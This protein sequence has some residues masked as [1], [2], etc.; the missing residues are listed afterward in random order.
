MASAAFSNS[1]IAII[2]DDPG[3]HGQQLTQSLHMRGYKSRFVRLQDCH[4]DLDS[5]SPRINLPGFSSLPAGVFVRGVPGGSLEQVVYYL[6]VLHGLEY[7]GV[8][9]FNNT[10]GIERS[11]DKGMTSYLLKLNGI[12]TPKSFVSSDLHY[13]NEKIREYMGQG[14][15][16][17]LKPIFGSQGKGLQLLDQASQLIDYE[18]MHGVMYLQEYIDAGETV[19]VDYRVFVI[20]DQVIAC[21][22]RTG[23]SWITNV[24]QGGHV[25]SVTLDQAVHQMAIDATRVTE[26]EYAGVDLIRDKEGKFWVTEVNSVPAWKGLQQTTSGAVVDTI[27]SQ[28]LSHCGLTA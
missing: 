13:I 10:R 27:S 19:G 5:D 22:K 6:D 14:K 11:V 18:H 17:V 4:F 12:P 2:T 23:E 8:P 21:M 26:L 7:A 24:A 25:E 28:F 16:L 20:G 1:D 3:W 9:V 15:K